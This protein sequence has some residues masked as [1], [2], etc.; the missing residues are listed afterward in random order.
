MV[1]KPRRWVSLPVGCVCVMRVARYGGRR[2]G[3]GCGGGVRD[4]RLVDLHVAKA[5]AHRRRREAW[6][7][8]SW[9]GWAVLWWGV[10][11]VV[12]MG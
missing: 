12:I 3:C 9:L 6:L 5:G 8:C 1:T 4:Q 7:G 11:M 2:S 10:M